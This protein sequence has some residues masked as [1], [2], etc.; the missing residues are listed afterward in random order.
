MSIFKKLQ[1]NNK[2]TLGFNFRFGATLAILL[3]LQTSFA[4]SRKPYIEKTDPDFASQMSMLNHQIETGKLKCLFRSHLWIGAFGFNPADD[5]RST[6]TFINN[7][8][9][10]KQYV[11]WSNSEMG[12][13]E[14]EVL[15]GF[16]SGKLNLCNPDNFERTVST[17]RDLNL[18]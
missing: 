6:Y 9:R 4:Q 8:G 18:E 13:D 7:E 15:A 5:F 3:F 11:F 14:M 10:A 2:M 17:S 16:K 12:I 1:K